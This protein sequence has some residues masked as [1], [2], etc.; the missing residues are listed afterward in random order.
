M[1]SRFQIAR[2]R[3][4]GIHQP[5]LS[6]RMAKQRRNRSALQ[7]HRTHPEACRHSMRPPPA[8]AAQPAGQ[9]Q[10]KQNDA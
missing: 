7:M 10:E 5:S 9:G 6:L 1:S 4:W 8:I 2:I 3:A